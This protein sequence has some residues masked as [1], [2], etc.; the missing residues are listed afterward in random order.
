MNNL[1]ETI[2][3]MESED[4]VDRFIAEYV[5]T[6]IRYK[7]LHK[8]IVKYE[9]G[10]LNFDP[11]C[12]IELFSRQAKAMGEYLHTLEIRAEIENIVLPE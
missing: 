6:K 4:Y 1:K 9:A 2:G 7:K 10:T 8:M 11:T 12:S 5:Q 3:L